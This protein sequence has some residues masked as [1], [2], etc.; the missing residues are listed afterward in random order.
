SSGGAA[1]GYGGGTIWLMRAVCACP[2]PESSVPESRTRRPGR[3]GRRAAPGTPGSA[4]GAGGV[5]R[6]YGLSPDD[7][8]WLEGGDVGEGVLVTLRDGGS[9]ARIDV[10]PSPW[11][12]ELMGGPT[13]APPV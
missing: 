11:V 13:A 8:A 7:G 4:R 12:L 3:G 10:D 9:L 1:G 5:A 6:R 2:V